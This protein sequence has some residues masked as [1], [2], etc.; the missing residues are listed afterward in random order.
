MGPM[1]SENKKHRNFAW[2]SANGVGPERQQVPHNVIQARTVV[3]QEE[4]S[5]SPTPKRSV[6]SD[7]G[8]EESIMENLPRLP[9][10]ARM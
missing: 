3:V 4:E 10:K 5:A 2:A 1:S 6:K 8:S 9:E 7:D